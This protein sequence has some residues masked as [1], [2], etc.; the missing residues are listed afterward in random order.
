MHFIFVSA[1][2]VDR[3]G[4]SEELW[5]R[6]AL[7]LCADSHHITASM[8]YGKRL[9]PEV[10]KL[11]QEGIEIAVCEPRTRG[12]WVKGWRKLMRLHNPNHRWLQRQNPDLVVIS[13]GGTRDGLEW[14]T[15]CHERGLP[16]VVIVQCNAEVWWPTDEIGKEMAATYAAAKKVF[17]VSHHNLKLLE[18]Q[19][20]EVL[21]NATV[22]WNPNKLSAEPP[23]M[24]PRDDGVLK[25]ACVARLD[26]GAKGQDMLFHVLA[27]ARWRSRPIELNLYGAG[28]CERSVRR[29][30]ERLRLTNV[31]FRG[32]VDCVLGIWEQ[33]HLLV[34]PSRYEGLPLALVEAM[35]C[36]RP[37]VVT[38][39]G[40]NAELCVDGESGFVVPAPSVKLLD[41]TMER[42]W[43]RRHEWQA[44]GKAARVRVGH[45]ISKDPIGEF[46]QRL[47][48][49]AL[50]GNDSH[51][52]DATFV[53]ASA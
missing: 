40:G 20:G 46:R 38:D 32:R 11:K 52:P 2:P 25:F 15:L 3:W 34:L 5:S 31:H 39:I 28:P 10:A 12:M 9:S 6:A 24:W 53:P 7:S 47:I 17:C 23:P 16:F 22:V 29:L 4:G 42:A 37:A 26:P 35:W 14:M 51:I 43:S 36:A 50:G 33:N 30:A 45:L 44:M 41:E 27:Q 18:H 13:Q 8:E 19:I 48:G 1:M 21:P 49:A